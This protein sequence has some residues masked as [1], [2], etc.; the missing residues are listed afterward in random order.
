MPLMLKSGAK[1]VETTFMPVLVGSVTEVKLP[2]ELGTR[3][4]ADP[5]YEEKQLS[6]SVDFVAS[7]EAP[8]PAGWAIVEPAPEVVALLQR[9]GIEMSALDHVWKTSVWVFEISGLSRSPAKFQGHQLVNLRG[10]FQKGEAELQP[11]TLLVRSNQ[12]LG[13]LAGDLLDPHSDDSFFTWNIFDKQL[14]QASSQAKESGVLPRANVLRLCE[15]EFPKVS[16]PVSTLND[17]PMPGLHPLWDGKSNCAVQ[18]TVQVVE[19]GKR[20]ADRDYELGATWVGRV[21][22]FRYDDQ[23]FANTE[24]LLAALKEQS[25]DCSVLIHQSKAVAQ[26]DIDTLANALG[27]AGF[28]NVHLAPYEE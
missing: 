24:A 12:P 5:T 15:S 17:F 2:G 20:K 14:A 26:G 22:R 1:P 27:A 25:R 19:P 11:G 16:K 18:I 7:R 4:V 3:Y 9:H 6:V 28:E 8:M 10:E 23:T 21:L 13:R